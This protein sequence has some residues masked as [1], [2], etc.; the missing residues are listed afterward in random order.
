MR[1][2]YFSHT[3]LA[4]P[5]QYEAKKPKNK[6]D[7]GFTHCL[8]QLVKVDQLVIIKRQIIVPYSKKKSKF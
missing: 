6:E 7:R 1:Y 3:G 2:V 8:A 4:V 5:A